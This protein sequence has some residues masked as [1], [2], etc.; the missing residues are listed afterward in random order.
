MAAPTA[1]RATTFRR[2]R[3]N[4]EGPVGSDGLSVVLRRPLG[5][6][7]NAQA[8]AS[9]RKAGQSRDHNGSYRPLAVRVWERQSPPLQ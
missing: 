5:P 2:L 6:N 9:R 1:T 8:N 3:T 4:A 7:S